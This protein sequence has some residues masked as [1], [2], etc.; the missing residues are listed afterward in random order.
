MFTSGRIRIIA[1]WCAD[2][3]AISVCWAFAVNAYWLLGRGLEAAGLRTVI[4][5]YSPVDYLDFWPVALVF[6][7]LNALFDNYQGSWMYPSAPQ[8]PIEEFRRLVGASLLTHLGVIAF[9][10]FAFQTTKGYSRVVIAF[11]GLLAALGTQS[12][13]NWMRAILFRFKIGQIPVVL[14]GAGD[15]AYRVATALHDD[16]HAGFRIV[17]YFD[18]T[19]RLG[20]RKRRTCW[21]DRKLADLGVPYLGSLRA[22]VSVARAKDIKIL[23]ACQDERLFRQQMKEFAAWFTFI[24]YLTTTRAFPVYGAR[25]IVFDGIGGLE[26]VNQGRMRAQRVQKRILD[27]ALAVLAF[28]CFLPFFILLP[29]LIKL[30]SRGPI[31][32]RQRRLG[33]KGVPFSV[34][35]FRSMYVDADERLAQLRRTN[36]AVDAEWQRNFKLANDPRV[37]P[38]GRL[39]RKTS[40]DEL[41][42][43]FNVFRGEM[44]LIGPRPIV[45]EEVAYYGESYSVFASVRPG[46]TGLWQVSGRSD[47]DYEQRVAL[48]SYYVL[49]WSSWMDLWILVRTVYAVLF[50]RGAR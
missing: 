23:I 46:I 20:R 45:E 17:G 30:T 1:L 36:P 41:P 38:L 44:A 2:V 6:T 37:T 33:L 43:L 34:W 4:G 15:V 11:S 13:R 5:G 9:L 19:E 25:P 22:C 35:K 3:L 49:N 40:L 39:L 42:Q 26:M 31:F 28:V 50:M 47:T 14:A 32:Y 18:G 10:A 12:F 21:N 29:I 8:P 24:E 27:L 16:R 7:A 48:D